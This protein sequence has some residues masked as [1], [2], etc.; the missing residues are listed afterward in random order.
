[1][2]QCFMKIFLQMIEH[3]TNFKLHLLIL[4]KW[5]DKMNK[6]FTK[7][8]FLS[9]YQLWA[10][11]L[12]WLTESSEIYIQQLLICHHWNNVLLCQLWLTFRTDHQ[13]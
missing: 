4:H 12:K 13:I 1:M 9:L 3:T 11:Q 6:Y 7:I 10:E 5:T 2:T 8:L